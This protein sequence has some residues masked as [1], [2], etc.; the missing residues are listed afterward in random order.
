MRTQKL[1][2]RFAVTPMGRGDFMASLMLSRLVFLVLEVALLVAFGW[3]A[4]DVAVHGSLLDL[5][6]LSLLGALAFT[7]IALLTAARAKTLEAANG[8]MNLVMVPMWLLSGSFFSYERFPDAVQ[9][10]IR[11][12]PLTALNDA[13]RA[14][15]NEG[16]PLAASWVEL[17]VL[18]GWTVVAFAA[19]LKLFRW[20]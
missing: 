2:R 8:I 16:Q 5:V 15:M 13:L 6:L 3:L 20:Q 12:L 11:A 1:L 10:A 9:P 17:L 14:V 19:A 4:F 7:G 18:G